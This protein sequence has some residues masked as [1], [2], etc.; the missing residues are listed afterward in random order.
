MSV[1]GVLQA[2]SSRSTDGAHQD[3]RETVIFNS[4][5]LRSLNY[6]LVL[7]LRV[8]V[9]RVCREFA[10]GQTGQRA[11]SFNDGVGFKFDV[12]PTRGAY[13][14]A[15]ALNANYFVRHKRR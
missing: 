12:I 8:R 4:A 1:G 7:I 2:L 13:Q 14:V 10:P 11:E 15:V 5:V 6:H 9:C 3:E